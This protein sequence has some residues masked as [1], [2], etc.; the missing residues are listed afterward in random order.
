MGICWYIINKEAKTFYELGKGCWFDLDADKEYLTDVECLEEFIFD[1]V[2]S[3]YDREVGDIDREYCKLVAQEL[4]E[5]C[6][7]TKLDN[8]IFRSDSGDDTI[9]FRALKYICTGTRYTGT[10]TYPREKMIASENRHLDPN[11]S[12]HFYD[13]ERIRR[14]LPFLVEEYETISE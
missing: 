3:L 1:D 13:I 10:E 12:S 14:S 9:V 11:T 8:I 6:K 2:F 7:G 5:F 4:Y